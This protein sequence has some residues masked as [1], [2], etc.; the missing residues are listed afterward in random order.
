[1]TKNRHSFLVCLLRTLDFRWRL[2]LLPNNMPEGS[3][4]ERKEKEH[5]HVRGLEGKNE[6]NDL[7]LLAVL[8]QHTLC[9]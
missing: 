2:G 9:A 4:L 5:M 8:Q 6:C 3:E 1:M 7:I